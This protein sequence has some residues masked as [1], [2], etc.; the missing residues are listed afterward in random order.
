MV[1]KSDTST[2]LETLEEDQNRFRQLRKLGMT[3]EQAGTNA[4]TW[5][6]YWRTVHSKTMTYTFTNEKLERLGLMNLSKTLRQ[7]QNA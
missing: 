4:N 1:E 2:N 7:I 6:G 5:K 3:K